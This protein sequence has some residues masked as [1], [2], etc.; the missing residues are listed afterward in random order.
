MIQE[1]IQAAAAVKETPFEKED[2][3]VEK[4]QSSSDEEYDKELPD[5]PDLRYENATTTQTT[6]NM[7]VKQLGGMTDTPMPSLTTV[8][9]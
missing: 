1:K 4:F 7:A 6:S 8:E 3:D 2:Y 9:Q 5:S